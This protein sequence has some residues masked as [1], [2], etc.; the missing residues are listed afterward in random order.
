M[1]ETIIVDLNVR[2]VVFI[3]FDVVDGA[4]AIEIM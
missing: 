2:Y 3:Y 1:V 4:C